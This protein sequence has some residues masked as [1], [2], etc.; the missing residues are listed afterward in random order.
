MPLKLNFLFSQAPTGAAVGV[1]TFG[2]RPLPLRSP[3]S[4][5]AGASVAGF[6]NFGGRPRFRPLTDGAASVGAE[7][8]AR[9]SRGFGGRPLGLGEEATV[10]PSGRSCL[11]FGGRPRPRRGGAFG[12]GLT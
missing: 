3:P 2:G 4:A 1:F 8:G 6:P 11:A 7:T 12:S 5:A 10:P 9:S